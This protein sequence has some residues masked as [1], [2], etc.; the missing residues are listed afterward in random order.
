[1]GEEYKKKWLQEEGVERTKV[2]KKVKMSKK[3][4]Y[5]MN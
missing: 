4:K 2:A 1:M 3:K 5:K